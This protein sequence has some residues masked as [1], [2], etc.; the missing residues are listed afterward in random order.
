MEVIVGARKVG[1]ARQAGKGE[2]SGTGGTRERGGPARK[3]GQVGK[4]GNSKSE[5]R[6]CAR[7]GTGLK[8]GDGRGQTDTNQQVQDGR[9]LASR[10][11]FHFI[12]LCHSL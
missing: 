4:A 9:A 10:L 1:H 7:G 6:C 8:K 5:T 2:E 11:K 12:G 3:A